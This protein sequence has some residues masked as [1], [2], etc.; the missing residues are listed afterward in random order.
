MSR[1]LQLGQVSQ[2]LTTLR[3]GGNPASRDAGSRALGLVPRAL[4][5]VPAARDGLDPL[6]GFP[7]DPSFPVTPVSPV[8]MF[9]IIHER[10]S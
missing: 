9:Y 2:S 7:P 6:G 1:P 5:L 10:G 3:L 8:F 4:G